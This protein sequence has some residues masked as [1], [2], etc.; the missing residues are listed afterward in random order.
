MVLYAALIRGLRY[1]FSFEEGAAVSV[2]AAVIFMS[3]A[4]MTSKYSN[5]YYLAAM[6]AILL[7]LYT[8]GRWTLF[9]SVVI[10][11]GGAAAAG[12]IAALGTM[13]LWGCCAV[14]LKKSQ[15]FLAG[16]GIILADVAINLFFAKRDL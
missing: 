4:I 8:G 7:S 6:F 1:K 14:A 3:L 9:L 11:A 16:L 15:F 10:G 5:I 12:D 13:V 2:F